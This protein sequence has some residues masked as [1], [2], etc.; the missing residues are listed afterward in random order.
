MQPRNAFTVDVEDYFQVTA[1]EKHIDRDDWDQIPH[2]VVENTQRI[3]DLLSEHD[4][5]ATF[6]VLGWVADK[7]PALV[8][9]IAT[10]GHE[11]GSHSYW[12][13]LVYHMT[14]EEFRTDLRRSKDAIEDATGISVE[15]Y[16]APS[17]SI[18]AQSIWALDI[19]VEEGFTIDSSIYPVLHDRYGMPGAAVGIHCVNTK[20][21]PIWEFPPSVTRIAGVN[22]P[23]SGGGYF[24]LYPFSLTARCFSR[25]NR[26]DAPFM[27]Y[28]HPWEVDPEQPRLRTG[29]SLSRF[30]HYVNLSSTQHKL[31]RLLRR[32]RFGRVRDVMDEYRDE[33]RPQ[34]ANPV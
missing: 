16:R 32:F 4:V 21:G 34:A 19:L 25:I 11:L 24:R 13:R 30:R 27:F 5:R 29:S 6:Y 33:S 18:T 14:P 9:R 12:H 1:F 28:I 26:S 15:A 10:D 23:V 7:Y 22:L 3:L 8:Q 17:F 2:H 31:H 20:A